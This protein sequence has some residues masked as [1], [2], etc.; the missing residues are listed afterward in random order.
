MTN[1]QEINLRDLRV[2][3]RERG[4]KQGDGRKGT[5]VAALVD[6]DTQAAAVLALLS[7]SKPKRKR[8]P[9][10]PH[11]CPKC[12]NVTA[13]TVEECGVRFGYRVIGGEQ[14]RQSW[15]RGCR[16]EQSA[17]TRQAD[18]RVHAASQK[19]ALKGAR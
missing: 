16:R 12:A 13:D 2:I 19:A 5:M 15:C 3:C 9:E 17:G 4:V 10:L 14:R 18:G 11:A 7:G 8:K 6:D 1:Y